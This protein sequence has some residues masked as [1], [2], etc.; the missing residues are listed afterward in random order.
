MKKY[1]KKYSLLLISLILLQ[2]II[3]YFISIELPIILMKSGMEYNKVN[4][5]TN[6]T[7]YYIPYLT[8]LVFATIILLDLLKQKIKGLPVVLLSVFSYYAGVLFFLFL[9]NNKIN[10]NDK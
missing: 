8:N 9:V 3:K 1:I 5:L 7:Y 4:F 2:G 6:T 10:Q